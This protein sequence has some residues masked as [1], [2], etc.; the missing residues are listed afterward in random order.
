MNIPRRYLR[1]NLSA[2]VE[3]EYSSK[4]WYTFIMQL[5]KPRQIYSSH[6]EQAVALN[7][8]LYDGFQHYKDKSN[9]RKS[10]Y[11]EGRYENIYLDNSDI[12]EIDQ[13]LDQVKTV[14]ATILQTDKKQLKAGLW[15]NEM[16]PGH[17]TLPHRHDDYNELLSAVY[18]VKVPENS[19]Q[20]VLTDR[21][22]KTEVTPKEGMFVFFPPDMIHEVT[23]NESDEV[24]LSLG[25][26]I[27]PVEDEDD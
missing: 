3:H 5:E 16:G 15:F 27:G 4:Y 6:I 12:S 21:Q 13:V 25:I 19:G 2:M 11:F 18:Y 22:F 7:Q 10:H 24:R 9:A 8:A 17:V 23:K 26:N 14:A 20:L 1:Q